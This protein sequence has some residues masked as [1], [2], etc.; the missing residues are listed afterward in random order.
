MFNSQ[1]RVSIKKI[2]YIKIIIRVN[3]I[4]I[5]NNKKFQ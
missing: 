1:E 3:I 5:N 4:I 2:N